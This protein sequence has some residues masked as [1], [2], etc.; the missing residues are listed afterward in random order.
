ME[1]LG[2]NSQDPTCTVAQ[3]M[4]PEWKQW[5]GFKTSSYFW[6]DVLLHTVQLVSESIYKG[7]C[8]LIR[9]VILYV[10]WFIFSLSFLVPVVF[11]NSVNNTEEII[12][13]TSLVNSCLFILPPTPSAASPSC[14]TTRKNGIRVLLS[15]L[16]KQIISTQWFF[17][18]F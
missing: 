4:R 6:V 18:S 9:N 17:W 10:G 14:W 1:L 16:S 15:D 5:G 7:L 11:V 3:L 12:I 13:Y 2:Y 8:M